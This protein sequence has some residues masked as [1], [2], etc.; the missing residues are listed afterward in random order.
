MRHYFRNQEKSGRPRYWL[1]VAAVT[2]TIAG[3]AVTAASASAATTAPTSAGTTIS[4]PVAGTTLW[5]VGKR[6]CPEV[7]KP[8]LASCDA[9]IRDVVAKGTKGAEKF[10]VGAGARTAGTIGPAG[11]LTPGDLGTAYGLKT[12]G[13]KGQTVAIVDAYNDPT[14]NADLQT[15]DGQ[16]DLAACSTTNGCLKVVGQTGSTTVLPGDDNSGWSVEESLD[17]EAVHSVCQGCKIILVEANSPEN[18]DLGTAEDAAVTLGATEVSNSFG[19]P[20]AGSDETFQAAFNH[21][22]VVITASAGDDG[23]YSY[24]E[25]SDGGTNQPSVPSA[26][27]T[28]VSVGGTSLYLNQ[29]GSRQSES[30]WNDNGPRAYDALGFGGPL[31]AGGG[32]CSTLFSARTWQTALAGWGSTGCGNK[33]SDSDVSAVADYLTG[34]D[35]Y[36]SNDCGEGCYPAP[37]WFTIGGTSLSSPV[38][39]A[40]WALAGGAH[41]VSYPALSL[42]GHLKQSY[43]VTTGGNGWCDGQ[44]AAQCPDPNLQGVGVIDCAYTATGT[45]SSGDRECDAL[46]GYDG[47][48][49]VG[50]PKGDTIFA[51]TGPTVA[52]S[53]DKT[54]T[55][56]KSVKF[57][58]AVTDPFP[59]GKASKYVWHWGDGTSST[60]TTASAS[61]TYNTG[62]VTRTITLDVTDQY[63]MTG[64]STH[65]VKVN[66]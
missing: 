30:V 58:A 64:S 47:P 32:G 10:T 17:V 12:T 27:N 34:F 66:K 59:A 19:E 41:G 35:V 37:G 36:D 7:A 26:Y 62:G 31:G 28:T 5:A 22:G 11:G 4:H 13:G 49:G 25:L 15:F 29:T 42:Y 33:R 57:K 3:S 9:V 40:A 60:T 46:T 54:V 38:I 44:G 48:T 55:K 61:H 14:I 8:G 1:T 2:A 16:Y 52:I 20:E 65:K 50:T 24:D 21:P 39:A 23:Y 56:G 45:V 18:T 63:S 51:K 43:D 53:G 6:A